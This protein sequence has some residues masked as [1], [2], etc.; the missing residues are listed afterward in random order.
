MYEE[1]IEMIIYLVLAVEEQEEQNTRKCYDKAS[2]WQMIIENGK[3]E[4]LK[5]ITD[6][7]NITPKTHPVN[8]I[9]NKI[10][11]NDLNELI[12]NFELVKNAFLKTEF[13]DFS[14]FE[15]DKE[16]ENLVKQIAKNI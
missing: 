5:D 16:V 13:K 1:I 8:I 11:K 9:F 15:D 2:E 4:G 3:E 6:L 12:K 14:G 10:N 7:V